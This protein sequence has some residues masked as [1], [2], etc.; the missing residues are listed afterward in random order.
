MRSSCQLMC[1]KW[2]CLNY[3]RFPLFSNQVLLVQTTI[4][5]GYFEI[6]SFGALRIGQESMF[7]DNQSGLFKYIWLD[8][9]RVKKQL[10]LMLNRSGDA[11]LSWHL[12]QQVAVDLKDYRLMHHF[13]HSWLEL[14][15]ALHDIN[16]NCH[17]YFAKYSQLMYEKKTSY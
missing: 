9:A 15:S 8:K 12:R 2:E 1:N 4:P 7:T 6:I 13:L 14:V 16:Y 5:Y 17:V 10:S 11:T 3:Y